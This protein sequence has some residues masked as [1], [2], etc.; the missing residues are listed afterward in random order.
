MLNKKYIVSIVT[1][2]AIALGATAV[3]AETEAPK[4]VL[5]TCDN[6]GNNPVV[7]VSEVDS[8]KQG[9]ML[10]FKTDYFSSP[11]QA[12]ESCNHAATTLQSIYD[13]HK[14]NYLAGVD[15][16]DTFAFCVARRGDA[17]DSRD[18]QQLFTLEKKD[19]D[20]LNLVYADLTGQEAY[21]DNTKYRGV[22]RLY[23]DLQRPWWQI[24]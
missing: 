1:G 9:T 22:V 13:N 20:Y 12:Q 5:I 18:A 4:S 14:D 3:S 17:C 15:T 21:Q 23:S 8:D 11:E 10:T 19:G 6:T 24:W 7:M 16:G 2:T